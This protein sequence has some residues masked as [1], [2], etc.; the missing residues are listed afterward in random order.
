MAVSTCG[1]WSRQTARQTGTAEP[2]RNDSENEER[3]GGLSDAGFQDRARKKLDRG[4][5]ERCGARIM[6]EKG[7]CLRHTDI[8]QTDKFARVDDKM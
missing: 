3:G 7:E 1:Q 6:T 4:A 8:G 2:D 5:G